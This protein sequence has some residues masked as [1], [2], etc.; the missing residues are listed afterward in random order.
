[1]AVKERLYPTEQQLVGFTNHAGQARFVYNIALEQRNMW[2]PGR[3][4]R[5]GFKSQSKE[6]TE[7]RAAVD[8]LRAGST[9]IQQGALRDL[10]RAFTNFFAGRA[11]Y[12]KR[13]KKADKQSFVVRDIV[14]KR[15]SKR[16][17][18]VFVPKVGWVKFR[19]TRPWKTVKAATS[20][21]VT[22]DSARTWHI[23]F[24][25]EPATFA[26]Q[27]TNKT[28]GVDR[29]VANTLALSTGAMRQAPS[30]TVGEQ[31]RFLALER[32]LA[33][34]T[35]AMMHLP[36]KERRSSRGRERTKTELGKLR[37]RL[38]N[39]RTDF[40][41]QTT[42]M[43]VREFDVIGIENLRI[44]NMVRRP[45]PK[46][47]DNG[48]FLPNG[49]AAKTGLNR[50]IHASCWGQFDIRLT[51]K[52]AST[53]EGARSVVERVDPKNTSRECKHCHHIAPENR[54]SQ[55]VFKCVKCGHEAHAD[56]NAAENI[57]ERAV[58]QFLSRST[59]VGVPV[60]ARAKNVNRRASGDRARQ[61][62]RKVSRVNQADPTAKVA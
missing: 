60:S 22:R 20:A 23:S 34:Q 12:P 27:A 62:H 38:K 32:R 58:T 7:L 50:A 39:R 49:A 51:Q 45:T 37:V 21:R 42:T 36:V 5:V 25:T 8:W 47:D 4:T 41:E 56:T 30:L 29:G 61:P 11:K 17:A 52:A 59:S 48:G 9:V 19:L 24:T 46:S 40:V 16:T 6:L 18:A 35:T 14:V 33:R 3:R 44:T 15:L 10:D 55:A 2:H 1:M 54:E 28:V 53:P 31:K 57:D 13:R 43:L 26:R